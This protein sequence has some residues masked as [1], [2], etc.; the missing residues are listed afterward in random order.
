M[1]LTRRGLL[2]V[3][4]VVLL[5][6]GAGVAYATGIYPVSRSDTII[7]CAL[8]QNGQL[9]VVNSAAQ[10]LPSE[11]VVT[12]AAP[13]RPVTEVVDCAHGGDLQH[14]IDSANPIEPLTI[15]IVGTCSETVDISRD[16]VTLQSGAPG[17]G[18]DGGIDVGGGREINLQDIKLSGSGANG[19]ALF[20]VDDA[21]VNGS[22]NH[23]DGNVYAEQDTDLGFANLT[24]TGCDKGLNA[25]WGSV[26]EVGGG[27][28]TGCTHAAVFGGWNSSIWLD[29]VTIS[30][31]G[32]SA[33]G[34]DT[35]ASANLTND[36]LSNNTGGEA[37]SDGGGIVVLNNTTVSGSN[38][39][40]GVH[41]GG[42]ADISDASVVSGNG[43]GVV[44][45]TGS[46]VTVGSDGPAGGGV[47]KN[48][49]GDGIE[50]L[51]G[52]TMF[53]S[54]P[55]E[56]TGNGGNGVTLSDTSVANFSDPTITGNTGWGV[57]CEPSPSVALIHGDTGHVTGNTGGD[58]NCSNAGPP[59]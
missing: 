2:A 6:G 11:N 23:I 34:L 20:A 25:T 54:D 15:S 39:G 8:K 9:R 46:H 50:L 49:T 40:V 12:L 14:A 4:V 17:S 45:D 3:A 24:M 5:A 48:N 27:S 38:V 1:A 16:R 7:G 57:F 55:A 13:P 53:I 36:T 41:N 56:V 21:V 31:A 42:S 30:G 28:I 59:G 44:V 29:G 19:F 43:K 47:V 35:G 22:N 33:V 10:C 52:S 58:V 51:E 37:I 32:G 18:I 26:I